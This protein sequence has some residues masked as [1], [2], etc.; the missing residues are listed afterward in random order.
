[1]ARAAGHGSLMRATTLRSRP[2]TTASL[3]P[4]Q[5]TTIP[6]PGSGATP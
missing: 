5:V 1:M 2:S 4:W 3:V 6:P